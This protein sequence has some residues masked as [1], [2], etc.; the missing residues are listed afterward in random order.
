[1][2]R[3]H[4][5]SSRSNKTDAGGGAG[6]GA[7]RSKVQAQIQ[8]QVQAQAQ[9]SRSKPSSDQGILISTLEGVQGRGKASSHGT[10]SK[11]SGSRDR[12]RGEKPE[13]GSKS[14]SRDKKPSSDRKE[15]P[16]SVGYTYNG[17]IILYR[18]TGRSNCSG[19]FYRKWKYFICCL[20]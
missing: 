2:P 1:M 6:G 8:A 12:R 11:D 3:D 13:R 5:T 16:R 14:S 9:A 4:R 7:G 17:R 10:T 19:F 18:S 15:D 20:F